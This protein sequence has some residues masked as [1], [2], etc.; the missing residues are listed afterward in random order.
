MVQDEERHLN[1]WK[2][3]RLVKREKSSKSASFLVL[4]TPGDQINYYPKLNELV[5]IGN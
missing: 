1:K 5:N 2:E 4:A 3:A